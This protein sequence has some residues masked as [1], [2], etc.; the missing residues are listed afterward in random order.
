MVAA[1]VVEVLADNSTRPRGD[2]EFAAIPSFGHIVDLFDS[3][4]TPSQLFRVLYVEHSP[5][6]LPK[7]KV[8]DREQAEIVIYVEFARPKPV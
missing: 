2:F 5:V 8:D 4:R 7:L 3:S 1:A 6:K